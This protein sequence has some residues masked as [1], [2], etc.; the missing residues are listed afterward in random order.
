MGRGFPSALFSFPNRA[1]RTLEEGGAEAPRSSYSKAAI[2]A[3]AAFWSTELAGC[4]TVRSWAGVHRS[5]LCDGTKGETLAL[6]LR[7]NERSAANWPG[8][9]LRDVLF[10]SILNW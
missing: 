10:L 2:W 7:R 9:Q 5:H 1:L 4:S 6:R 8:T 3:V